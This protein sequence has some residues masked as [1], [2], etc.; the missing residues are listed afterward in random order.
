MIRSPKV[1]VQVFIQPQSKKRMKKTKIHLILLFVALSLLLSSCGAALSGSSWPGISPNGDMLFVAYQSHVYAVR[2]ADGSMVWRF[3]EKAGRAMFYAAPVLAGNQLLVGDYDNVLHSLDPNTGAEKWTFTEA[4]GDW[5][6]SPLAVNNL[7]LAPNA[8]HFLY[9]LSLNGSLVWKYETGRALWS[10]PVSDGERAYQA[11]MDHNL[12]AIDLRTGQ[13][14]WSLDVG[15]AVIY[16]PTL[17]IDEGVIYLTTLARNL[18][19]IAT[20]DGSILWQRQFESGLWTQPAHK[21]GRLFF[22]DLQ[23]RIYAVSAADGSDI[24]SQTVDQP[25]TGQPTLLDNRVVFP[26]EEGTLIA[27][28]PDGER[29]WSK[30]FEGKLYTGPVV[31][32]ERL[33]VGIAGGKEFLKMVSLEGQDV[34][35]FVPPK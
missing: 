26:T 25:V 4:K 1:N 30:S 20:R 14:V 33:A 15:G 18:M 21:D 35:S 12:Y 16:S 22:G 23:G 5:I 31:V 24:W 8:D 10:Q 29:L 13:K 28:T 6:A 34:W 27:T 32:G 19:A 11:S 2:V 7:I 3:P 17:N 9:A